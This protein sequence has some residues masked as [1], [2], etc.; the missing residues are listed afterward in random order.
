MWLTRK[1]QADV[2]T[3]GKPGAAPQIIWGDW[4]FAPI[5]NLRLVL[6][7]IAFGC[8]LAVDLLQSWDWRVVM[9]S[10]RPIRFPY[11]GFGWLPL[12]PNTAAV[13]LQ[14]VLVLS[15]L[16]IA[17]GYRFRL[18][19][20]VFF[21]GYTYSFLVDRAYFNNHFYLIAL[22]AG[23]LAISNAHHRWSLDVQ[24]CPTIGC[25]KTPRWQILGP[26][27]QMA[28]PYLFGGLAKLNPDWL[29][30]EPVRAQLWE[31]VDHPLYGSLVSQPWSGILFAWGGM[32]FDMLIVPAL[33][34]RRSRVL[35]IVL[36]IFFHVTNSLMFSIGI[37]PW[38]GIATTVLYLP[39]RL[40]Y[41]F[42]PGVVTTNSEPESAGTPLYAS[43]RNRRLMI[44]ALAIWLSMQ[45]ALP[46]RHHLIPGNV[47][48]T[49]EGFYFAWTMKLDL[50]SCFLGFHICDPATGACLAIDHNKDLTDYQRYWLPREPRGIVRY[51]R[52]LKERARREGL[53]DAVIVCDSVCA[54]NGR[55]YQYMLD[56]AVDPAT[57][58]IPS[59]GHAA[60][61]VPLQVSAPIGN[62]KNGNEKEAEV[63]E[64]IQRTRV[65]AGVFPPRLRGRQ[66]RD[67][68]P[69][70]D[71][72]TDPRAANGGNLP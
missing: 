1:H 18:G 3:S 42:S 56:P 51:A 31:L 28:I 33:L 60:W 6:F 58:T 61:I 2:R 13:I 36:L 4:L 26:A 39:D 71:P 53:P 72:K 40:L 7:R 25:K 69:V 19:A 49:R 67:V 10:R 70:V 55:P 57:V 64:M 12:L 20:V 23:W 14:A 65:A 9:L 48:W 45:C 5:D 27:V 62:Y 35:A 63:M 66:L 47:G 46:L 50:K 59:W 24:R 52:F 43:R 41:R 68:T 34:W 29:R 54:L 15:C 16:S 38:L 11:D 22:F 44:G 37:F 8:L 17:T 21:V 30:G 32:I